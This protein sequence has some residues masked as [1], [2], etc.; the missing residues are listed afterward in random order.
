MSLKKIAENSHSEGKLP[1]VF[2]FFF[3]PHKNLMIW[4][5]KGPNSRNKRMKFEYLDLIKA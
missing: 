2:F 4:I 3:A 5:V 1:G